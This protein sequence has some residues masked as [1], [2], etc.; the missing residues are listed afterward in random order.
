MTANELNEIR[1]ENNR[2]QKLIILFS[3]QYISVDPG[4]SLL[5]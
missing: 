4:R 3:Y 1:R 5:I 2:W